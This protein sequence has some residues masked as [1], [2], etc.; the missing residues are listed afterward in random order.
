MGLPYDLSKQ[1]TFTTYNRDPYNTEPL[2]CGTTI[3]SD[4]RFSSQDIKFDYSVFDFEGNRFSEIKDIDPYIKLVCDLFKDR[5]I[6]VLDNFSQF[7]DEAVS[8][9]PTC[10]YELY[11]LFSIFSAVQSQV[12]SED[13]WLKVIN[14]IISNDLINLNP[15]LVK[16][17]IPV[18]GNVPSAGKALA[19]CA[20]ELHNKT[21]Q[22]K[23]DPIIRFES[24]KAF[25]NIVFLKY[26]L[27][28]TVSDLEEIL[29]KTKGIR[30]EILPEEYKLRCQEL[31][32][33][34]NDVN[35]K[36]YLFKYFINTGLITSKSVY[37]ES[38]LEYGI[39]PAIAEPA[40][41][42]LFKE[43]LN[44]EFRKSF[45]NAF[46]KYLSGNLREQKIHTQ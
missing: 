22:E 26:S 18:F 34:I 5:K 24:A 35:K 46:G 25:F 1:I 28:A 21:S 14:L 13:A 7:Y 9:S 36:I 41:Q 29:E 42:R 45:I 33:G 20:T 17:V 30:L 19:I 6:G 37:F 39:M 2:I 11:G 16:K 10:Q 44:A 27:T 4:F 23:I 38:L 32:Q 3:D 12:I 15:N 31:I 8:F 43:N 40:A